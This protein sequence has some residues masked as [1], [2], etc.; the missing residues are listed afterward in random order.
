M[1]K[2]IG[3]CILLAGLMCF[4]KSG[5][6][7]DAQ[8]DDIP[9]VTDTYSLMRQAVEYATK[10]DAYNAYCSEPSSMASNFLD[11]FGQSQDITLEQ[12]AAL[13]LLMEQVVQNFSQ[14]L[15]KDRPSCT[16]LEF[17]MGRLEVMSKLKDVSYLLNGVD[18]ATLPEDNIP[19]LKDLI[20][21]KIAE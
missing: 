5:Y 21:E 19:E 4:V 14:W 20:S 9:V 10:A 16:D 17:M 6:A 13:T 8:K 12:K 1:R 2:L 15:G 18:P 7:Q 3:L 11:K